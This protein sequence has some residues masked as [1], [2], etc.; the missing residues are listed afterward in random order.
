MKKLFLFLCFASLILTG[1]TSEKVRPAIRGDLSTG[2]I[3]AQESWKST[4]VMT[5]SGKTKAILKTGHLRM[6]TTTQET[7]LDDGMQVDFYNRAQVMSTTLTSK[8]GKV[9]DRTKNMFAYE[10]VVAKNDS[11]VVLQTE[12][13][14]WDNTRQKIVSDKFVTITTKTEK[15][16]GYGF[17]SDQ[18]LRNYIIYRITYVTN[19]K[20]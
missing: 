6:M 19:L 20:N 4:I 13:L 18:F 7:I 16:Q 15:M 17:E 1:C 2:E 11:G 3:P 12:E 10:N 14:M 5:D 9:D 8:R